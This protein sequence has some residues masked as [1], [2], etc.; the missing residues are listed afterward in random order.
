[1]DE[2]ERDWAKLERL[3]R[4][5]VTKTMVY[6]QGGAA[7]VL[8]LIAA[9][10][11]ATSPQEVYPVWLGFAALVSGI[12]VLELSNRRARMDPLVREVERLREEL[13][14][15]RSPGNDPSRPQDDGIE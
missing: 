13:A 1:M 15:L 14:S 2:R 6:V 11:W 12:N 5:P 10:G 8:A 7:L 3:I 9:I 4:K